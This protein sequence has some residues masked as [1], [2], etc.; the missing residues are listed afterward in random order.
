MDFQ[1]EMATVEKCKTTWL[2]RFPSEQQGDPWYA[3]RSVSH[4][5]VDR[6]PRSRENTMREILERLLAKPFIKIRPAFLRNPT[7]KRCLELDAYNEELQLGV[8]FNGIQHHAFPNPFHST[9]AQFE[10]QRQRDHL[11]VELCKKHNV[12]LIAVPHYVVRDELEEYLRSQLHSQGFALDRE[13]TG[14]ATQGSTESEFETEH[15]VLQA[16]A[17]IDISALTANPHN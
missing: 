3:F 9:R 4:H 14:L 17:G 8:E 11:K 15:D 2:K 7:S 13:S 12:T 16:L 5:W 1:S 6:N 10:A